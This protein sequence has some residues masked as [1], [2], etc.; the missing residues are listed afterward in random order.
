MEFYIHYSG[1]ANFLKKM[2]TDYQNELQHQ[3]RFTKL[4]LAW[5][6]SFF[7]QTYKR[8]LI[9]LYYILLFSCFLTTLLILFSVMLWHVLLILFFHD[10]QIKSLTKTLSFCLSVSI[11][12]SLS[13]CVCLSLSWY[14]SFLSLCYFL[15]VND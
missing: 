4:F 3:N 6:V 8:K 7:D 1:H 5:I 14:L 13:L 11:R 2:S 9:F 12:L 15:A 10:G